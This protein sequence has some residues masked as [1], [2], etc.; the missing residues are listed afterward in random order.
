VAVGSNATMEAR[1]PREARAHRRGWA[2]EQVAPAAAVPGGAR[3]V[4]AAADVVGIEV[5]DAGVVNDVDTPAD[6]ARRRP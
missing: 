1:C 2:T 4:I 3:A 5:D 6:A